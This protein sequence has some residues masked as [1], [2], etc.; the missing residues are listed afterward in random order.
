M[1][2]PLAVGYRK[3]WPGR[4]ARR[5]LLGLCALA[6]VGDVL[7]VDVRPL[8]RRQA[9]LRARQTKGP[10]SRPCLH[11]TWHERHSAGSRPEYPVEPVP[12]KKSALFN[13]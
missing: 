5:A 2:S 4:Q 7:Q 8:L 1:Y 3:P 10:E 9:C 12:R 11:H 6:H 13:T